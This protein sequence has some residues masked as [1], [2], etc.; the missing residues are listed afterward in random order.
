MA[1]KTES[2]IEKRI[3]SYIGGNEVK[4]DSQGGKE[5]KNKAPVICPYCWKQFSIP[6]TESQVKGTIVNCPHCG[7]QMRL[8]GKT[9]TSRR[10]VLHNFAF[11]GA[12]A[13]LGVIGILI[14]IYG[15]IERNIWAWIALG[16]S[17]FFIGLFVLYIVLTAYHV[18][19][20]K[21]SREKS[22]V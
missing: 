7:K 19:L 11:L 14:W 15:T 16:G 13:I 21:T 6:E 12:F 22:K 4:T 18:I 3:K 5:S 2:L 20:I 1:N 17:V 9:M 10:W 8:T